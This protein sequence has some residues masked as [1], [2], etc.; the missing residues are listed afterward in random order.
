MNKKM[1]MVLVAAALIIIATFTIV[2]VDVFNTNALV[3]ESKELTEILKDEND[4]EVLKVTV[5]IPVVS[6]DIESEDTNINLINETFDNY[7]F[8]YMKKVKEELFD[9]AKDN[10]QYAT[11]DYVFEA[12][13]GYEI[14]RNDN[15]IF[16]VKMSDL[17]Y[18]G[19]AHGSHYIEGLNFDLVNSKLIKFEDLFT[20][21]KELYEDKLF[22][23][24]NDKIKNMIENE[25]AY[26]FDDYENNIKGAFK[27]NL[28][29]L[30][31]DGITFIYEEYEI[32][33]YAEGTKFIDISYKDIK[34][35]INGSYIK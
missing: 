14:V 16:S 25:D 4:K 3:V 7:Y 26:F 22:N 32:S 33:A 19:G 34:D 5:N 6:G 31:D 24:I 13:N 21:P 9:V 15:K 11:G 12:I 23:L 28:F 10:M 8:S 1:V 35:I 18:A 29:L 30:T 27:D 20:V 17:A 2:K